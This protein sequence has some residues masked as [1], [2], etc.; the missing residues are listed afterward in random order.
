MRGAC[1]AALLCGLVCLLGSANA[2]CVNDVQT[3]SELRDVTDS[4]V[5]QLSANSQPRGCPAA[6]KKGI[7]TSV[8]TKQQVDNAYASLNILRNTLNSSLPVTI[9]HYG[10]ELAEGV[11]ELFRSQFDG[12]DFVDIEPLKT[13]L[14]HKCQTAAKPNGFALKAL[15]MYHAHASYEHL[16]W[17]DADNFLLA[18]PESLFESAEYKQ[19]GNM[20]WPDFFGGWVTPEIYE[21][22]THG[23]HTPSS[24]ANTESGQVLLNTC[25]HQ[26]VLELMWALNEH[27]PVT[28]NYMFGDKDTF[29]LAFALADKVSSFYQLPSA[30]AGAYTTVEV[31]KE[32]QRIHSDAEVQA[33][34]LLQAQYADRCHS[35]SPGFLLAMMQVDP[36]GEPIFLHRTNA[37]F[38]L[39][40]ER[41]IH[42]EFMV[43]PRDHKSIRDLMWQMPTLGWAICTESTQLLMTPP[44]VDTIEEVAEK[45]LDDLRMQV[46]TGNAEGYTEM[47]R[48]HVSEV[49]RG[50]L[51]ELTELRRVGNATNSTPSATPTAAPTQPAYQMTI[52]QAVTLPL[53]SVSDY[54]GNV[55]TIA[56]TAYALTISCWDTTNNVMKSYCTVSSSASSRRAVTVTFTAQITDETAAT[57][58][59]SAATA[60]A[61]D[62]SSFNNNIATAKTQLAAAQPSVSW[63]SVTVPS[64]TGAAAPTTAVVTAAP[65]SPTPS[66]PTPST[67]PTAPTPTAPTPT[68]VQ[69]DGA[70]T[71]I[72]A[73]CT[74]LAA[75][76]AATLMQR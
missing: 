55:K 38:S 60:L 66:S 72:P 33:G 40:N 45:S 4:L 6:G 46:T 67:T 19:H 70:S 13:A 8:G 64:S 68:A 54:T 5:Q 63:S 15:G 35:S 14:D 31:S 27:A 1:A 36:S 56:E 17:L 37:E 30:P 11:M 57:T 42:T 28:Y 34:E 41:Q 69:V 61:S 73:L 18:N 2:K 22:L 74:L 52:T 62:I 43:A 39:T 26:D 24:A 25:Q 9:F 65:T 59:S 51:Y 10:D 16:L 48:G 75:L 23:K 47:T 50:V 12:I 21:V 29:R 49:V 58:A 44:D 71:A 20:F 3:L 32:L 53:S 7:A 76:A